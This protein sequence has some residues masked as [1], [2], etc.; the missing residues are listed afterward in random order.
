M[1][2]GRIS[3][4]V[5][6]FHVEP[7]PLGPGY[8][9]AVYGW[10]HSE[11]PTQT[12]QLEIS[13][14]NRIVYDITDFRRAS[15]DV[16]QYLGDVAANA[17]F[18]LKIQ[19]E[20]APSRPDEATINILF[21]S[22]DMYSIN[23]TRIFKPYLNLAS[24][25]ASELVMRFDSLGD[26]C[27]FGLMQR[28]TGAERLGLFRYAGT[29]STS[30][31]VRGI[32]S[33]FAGFAT[34]EDL[35]FHLAQDEW[36][37]VSRQYGYVFHTRRFQP[38]ITEDQIR[39]EESARLSFLARLLLEDIEDGNKIFVRRAGG[40]EGT[41]PEDGMQE[42]YRALRAVG[43]AKL[44]WVSPGDVAPAVVHLG[45]GLY[46]GYIGRLAPYENAYDFSAADWIALLSLAGKMIDE[47][48]GPTG[49]STSTNTALV[50]SR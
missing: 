21:A 5:E 8:M 13:S 18:Q 46:R 10:F 16:V 49:T 30:A 22:G 19:Y 31:L 44:L 2:A 38:F 35:E 23:I 50:G 1:K 32:D 4:A 42:L 24:I 29:L 36:I 37:G 45:D 39:E 20:E 3:Y 26:S 7:A 40:F 11:S 27:E 17:R 47:G 43:P 34:K 48:Q 41:D 9:L 6:S 15:P 28:E 25:A 14:A 12:M 33:S